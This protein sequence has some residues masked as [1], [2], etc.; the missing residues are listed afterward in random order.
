MHAA[1]RREVAGQ[2]EGSVAQLDVILLLGQLAEDEPRSV[3]SSG[4]RGSSRAAQPRRKPWA[5]SR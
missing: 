3:S 5:K 1:P 2:A 4:R